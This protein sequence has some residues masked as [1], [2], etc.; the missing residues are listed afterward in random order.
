[1]KL[2]SLLLPSRVIEEL[3]WLV[4]E[5][6]FSSRSE[7]IRHAISVMLMTIKMGAPREA[8]GEGEEGG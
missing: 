7:A 3:D 8:E 5:G 1:M 6:Y 4:G 2:I